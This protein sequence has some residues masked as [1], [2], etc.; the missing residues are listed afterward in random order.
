MVF[1]YHWDIVVFNFFFYYTKL[2]VIF[3][4]IKSLQKDYHPNK[5]ELEYIAL[6]TDV[7]D[8]YFWNVIDEAFL[9]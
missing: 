6:N 9:A 5:G 7:D 8:D 3:D 1:V 4:L 2:Y